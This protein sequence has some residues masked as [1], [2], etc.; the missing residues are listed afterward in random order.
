MKGLQNCKPGESLGAGMV[1]GGAKHAHF[2]SNTHCFTLPWP[3][4]HFLSK[5]AT[6][7]SP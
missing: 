3:Q 7:N 6:I 1:A 2:I 4:P 5:E